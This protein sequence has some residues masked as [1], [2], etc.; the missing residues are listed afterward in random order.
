MGPT[1]NMPIPIR[2]CIY[3]NASSYIIKRWKTTSQNRIVVGM[4]PAP[5]T[6]SPAGSSPF[7]KWDPISREVRVPRTLRR[8][9]RPVSLNVKVCYD[10]LCSLFVRL[11]KKCFEWFILIYP[12]SFILYLILW[13]LKCSST[14]YTN[15]LPTNLC[16]KID[17]ANISSG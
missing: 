11:K 5:V 9:H 3:T 15:T 6:S 1:P 2:W 12:E 10:I 7:T 14:F 4:D 13:V 17:K 8:S 16:T